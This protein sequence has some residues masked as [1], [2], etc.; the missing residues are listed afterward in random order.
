MA[1]TAEDVMLV[2]P[3]ARVL[4]M[5]EYHPPLAGR[6]ALRLDFNE[7]TS[8]PSPRVFAKLQQLSAEGL[9]IYPERTPVERIVAAHFGLASEQVLLTNGVDEAIHLIACTFLDEGDEALVWVPSFF[10]YDVSISLMTP[11]LKR[12]QSDDSLAFPR[13]RFLAGITPKTKLIIVASPNNPT[14]AT[15]AREDLLA[16]AAAAPHAVLMVD[17]AYFHFHG[18]TML[19][20]VNCIPNLLVTRTFSKAY[21]LANLRVGMVVGDARLLGFLRKASS[22]YNVNGVALAVL[23]EAI[24]DEDYLNWYVAQM[25]AGRERAFAELAKLGVPTWPSAANFV[26]MDIGPKH[27]QLVEAMRERGVLLRDRSS[28]PGCDGYVRLTIGLEDQMTQGL[29]ALK[30]SLDAI[31][32]T[33]AEARHARGTSSEGH[34]Y[35]YE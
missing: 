28:D 8:A 34:E 32:W 15:V 27:K 1:L 11:G 17:E 7:N 20:E 19:D 14:G 12:V 25:R 9:T 18:E 35:E 6:D 31:G 5:P 22:P 26:L 33:P 21:G 16:I 23:P 3:R 29:A 2:Q 4:A 24:A 30:D 13:E 10:M